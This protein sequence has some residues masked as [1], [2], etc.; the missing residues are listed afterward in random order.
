MALTLAPGGQAFLFI[1]SVGSTSDAD[2]YLGEVNGGSLRNL[3]AS[4]DARV[5]YAA[6]SPDEQ[7]IAIEIRL[8]HRGSDWT[9]F[10]SQPTYRP[11]NFLPANSCSLKNMSRGLNGLTI[12]DRS[13]QR[14]KERGCKRMAVFPLSGSTGNHIYQ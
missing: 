7:R 12:A 11:G 6:W 14:H 1:K 10:E 9:R 5:D 13:H 4:L 8:A 3:T 2:L